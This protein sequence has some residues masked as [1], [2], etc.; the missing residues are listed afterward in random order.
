MSS[1]METHTFQKHQSLFLSKV[2]LR[3][4][5][6]TEKCRYPVDIH[7]C[8]LMPSL[9]FC[10][11]MTNGNCIKWMQIRFQTTKYGDVKQLYLEMRLGAM[12][13]HKIKFISTDLQRKSW[14]DVLWWILGAATNWQLLLPSMFLND[15]GHFSVK[16]KQNLNRFVV[17]QL[18]LLP[19]T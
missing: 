15:K 11:S 3:Y 17:N 4:I 13:M 18:T 8:I 6:L 2:S 12:S 14:L 5:L 9:F 16:I 19:I 1:L 7:C 10:E